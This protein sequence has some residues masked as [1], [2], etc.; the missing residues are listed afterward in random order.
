MSFTTP[1]IVV[2][3]GN[4]ISERDSNICEK[5]LRNHLAPVEIQKLLYI[6][7]LTKKVAAI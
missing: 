1:C 6:T 4:F 5:D 2:I 7:F 3:E